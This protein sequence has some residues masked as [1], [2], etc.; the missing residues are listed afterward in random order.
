MPNLQLFQHSIAFLDDDVVPHLFNDVNDN[1]NF[2]SEY[3]APLQSSPVH[4][5]T[6]SEAELDKFVGR[7][8][9][10]SIEQNQMNQI[11]MLPRHRDVR[12]VTNMFKPRGDNAPRFYQGATLPLGLI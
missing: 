3:V 5:R 10:N 9:F 2:N 1:Y 4:K 11:Q 6:A 8:I 12:I 7:R